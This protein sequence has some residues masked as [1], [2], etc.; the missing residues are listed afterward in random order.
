MRKVFDQLQNIGVS[1]KDINNVFKLCPEVIFLLE[2]YIDV[3]NAAVEIQ[4]V[5][6]PDYEPDQKLAKSIEKV[7]KF[8]ENKGF[9]VNYSEKKID[10]SDF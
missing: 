4:D 6:D 1:D 8:I 3:F 2:K 9:T 10:L 7:K 5:S